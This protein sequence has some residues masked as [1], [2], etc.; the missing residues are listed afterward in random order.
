LN[1]RPPGYEPGELPDCSTPRRGGH[2]SRSPR[3]RLRASYYDPAMDAEARRRQ[4]EVWEARAPLWEERRDRIWRDSRA[5]SEWLVAAVDPQPGD[6]ILELAS[7]TGDTGFLAADRVGPSG[8]VISTDL[9]PGMLAA[10]KRRAVKLGITNV[11]FR[12]LDAERMDLEDASIDGVLCRWGYMLLPDPHAAFR[13][14]HRL[15]RRRGRLAFSVWAAPEE[16]RWETLLDDILV[17]ERVVEPP[18]YDAVGNM[19]SLAKPERVEQLLAATG[20][21]DPKFEEVP[22]LWRYR[23]VDDYWEMEA[24]LPGTLSESIRRLDPERLAAVRSRVAEALEP[25]RTDEGYAIRGTAL[26]VAATVAP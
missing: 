5:V 2:Y 11:D 23:D 10:A 13:E 20:F 4:Y 26:N 6:V 18:D 24:E 17:S 25:Y 8:R 22:V 9:S 15:L 3:G 1:L 19:F 7:G 21:S 14:T 12:T 16:N